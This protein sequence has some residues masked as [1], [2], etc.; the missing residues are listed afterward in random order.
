MWLRCGRDKLAVCA[1]L[2]EGDF[3]TPADRNPCLDAWP[4]RN[5]RRQRSSG[6]LRCIIVVLPRAVVR[7]SRIPRPA[8][9]TSRGIY[10]LVLCQPRHALDGITFNCFFP[11]HDCL[12][13][14]SRY[15]LLCALEMKSH[16][17]R[18]VAVGLCKL[19]WF[20]ARLFWRWRGASV[21]HFNNLVTGVCAYIGRYGSLWGYC[22]VDDHRSANCSKG[23]ECV[24]AHAESLAWKI[25]SLVVWRSSKRRN[26]PHFGIRH[27]LSCARGLMVVQGPKASLLSL[28]LEYRAGYLL[29]SQSC[30]WAQGRGWW[31]DLLSRTSKVDR[32]SRF[33]S[34]LTLFWAI[35][36]TLS[37]V[38]G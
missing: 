19:L 29:R 11:S 33:P 16:T 35:S 30:E 32:S 5:S 10:V 23:F 24:G 15:R 18:A 17:I 7:S 6:L 34:T 2:P 4:I 25:T 8:I 22:H 36:M 31:P 27:F 9:A 14:M 12:K 1:V 37:W 26:R 28:S 21:V 13:I 3:W 38:L 20:V